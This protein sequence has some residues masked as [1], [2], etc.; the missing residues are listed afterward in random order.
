M[1]ATKTRTFPV[2]AEATTPEVVFD[3]TAVPQNVRRVLPTELEAVSWI[4]PMLQEDFGNPPLEVVLRWM[5][6]WC[7]D[8]QY[9]FV[10]TENAV[11][12]ACLD[13]ED[14]RFYSLVRERFTYVKPGCL[15]EGLDIYRHWFQW[16]KTA[17]A[18]RFE[19]TMVD[20]APVGPIKRMFAAVQGKVGE[21]NKEP[22][23]D[24]WPRNLWAVIIE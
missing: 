1:S 2:A 4:M 15:A 19:F 8:N 13:R 9:S 12:L 3:T 10:R 11:G 18:E 7:S 16:G 5:R 21:G 6:I 20:G 24:M 22:R 23:P 17:K 14:M